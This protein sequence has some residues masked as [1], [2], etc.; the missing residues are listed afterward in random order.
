[1]G[2]NISQPWADPKKEKVRMR[3]LTFFL[4]LAMSVGI[5]GIFGMPRAYSVDHECT[6]VVFVGD[7][8]GKKDKESNV[9]EELKKHDIENVAFDVEERRGIKEVSDALDKADYDGKCIIVEAGTADSRKSSEQIKKEIDDFKSAHSSAKHIYWVAPVN[10]KEKPDNE[11][12]LDEVRKALEEADK[13]DD[14]FTVIDLQDQLSSPGNYQ[15]NG[16][17]MNDGGY[18][19][20]AAAIGAFFKKDDKSDTSSSSSPSSSSPTG[21]SSQPTTEKPGGGV[22]DPGTG[23][24]LNTDEAKEADPCEET[25]C[26]NG[27]PSKVSPRAFAERAKSATDNTYAMN[28]LASQRWSA[29]DL[30]VTD[31]LIGEDFFNSVATNTANT[32]F[33]FIAAL[34]KAMF[35]IFGLSFTD[36]LSSVFVE[37]ADYTFGKLIG[38]D[39]SVGK[40]GMI[41]TSFITIVAIFAAGRALDTKVAASPRDRMIG[42]GT[43]V[44][45]FLIVLT[46][47][48]F[49]GFQS[50]KNHASITPETAVTQAVSNATPEGNMGSADIEYGKPASERDGKLYHPQSWEPVSFGWITSIIY[51]VASN[52]AN[53]IINIISSVTVGI[54]DSMSASASVLATNG[55]P[56]AC[57]RFV[58]SMHYTFAHTSTMSSKKPVAKSLIAMDKMYVDIMMKAYEYAYGGGTA[59]GGD[60]WCWSTEVKTTSGNSVGD[61][62][63][64]AR[65]AGLYKEG[66][67]SGNLMT[68][69][70]NYFNGKGSYNTD[71]NTSPGLRNYAGYLVKANGD[72]TSN[73]K[74]DNLPLRARYYMGA[75]VNAHERTKYYFAVC[76]WK[77]TDAGADIRSDW[78]RVR[79]MGQ[80]GGEN[81]DTDEKVKDIASSEQLNS[82]NEEDELIPGAKEK[83]VQGN[84]YLTAQ[85]GPEAKSPFLVKADCYAPRNFPIGKGESESK[86]GFPYDPKETENPF[87]RRWDYA[88]I[89]KDLAAS[90]G[91]SAYGMADKVKDKV[92]PDKVQ[93]AV[94]EHT[95]IDDKADEATGTGAANPANKF[96]AANNPNDGINYAQSFWLT[97]T[98]QTPSGWVVIVIVAAGCMIAFYVLIFPLI[99]LN[100]VVNLIMSLLF[101]MV[102]GILML[103]LIGMAVKAGK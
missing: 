89:N 11:W 87:T 74:E 62:M 39:P 8:H 51:W 10:S 56:T 41:F 17:Q 99:V 34:Q 82:D 37:V 46:F 57:D 70:G 6:S 83:A 28:Y 42:F 27:D 94:S 9:E 72:W 14:N 29:F 47:L 86:Y 26:Y 45:K 61:W 18:S 90:I 20:R 79:A 80:T 64:L 98:G 58:D 3:L 54:L 13:P 78:K 63:M 71:A 73:A 92:V 91:R 75:E 1:M 30:P 16:V 69:S 49:I 84:N 103:S 43:T 7:T 95:S 53:A 32:I 44:G 81:G 76:E 25:S 24:N 77:P 96:N 35:A 52:L 67:G 21:T 23:E 40:I 38:R 88:D 101:V 50:S 22:P 60:T 12:K 48:V 66:I 36:E 68:N 97:T 4:M 55:Q 5:F 19:Q 85:L 2:I 15:D 65:G 102:P 31:R 33:T 59:S 100:L 93:D